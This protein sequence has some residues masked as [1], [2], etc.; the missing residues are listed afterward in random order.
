MTEKS[1]AIDTSNLKS[2]IEDEIIPIA[3]ELE[4]VFKRVSRTIEEEM[5]RAAKASAVSFKSM[6]EEIINDLTRLA[7]E[8]YI[9]EPL[10]KAILNALS[11]SGGGRRQSSS[12]LT[13]QLTDI[14]RKGG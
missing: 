2:S 14:I 4:E 9:K 12:Q 1:N 13:N 8:E 3:D 6:V 10:E 7:V 11:G 5:A